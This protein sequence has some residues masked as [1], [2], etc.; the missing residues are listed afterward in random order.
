MVESY[1]IDD[2]LLIHAF[3]RDELKEFTLKLTPAELTTCYLQTDDKSNENR[4][5]NQNKWLFL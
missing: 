1:S 3:R 4:I 2:E 5:K